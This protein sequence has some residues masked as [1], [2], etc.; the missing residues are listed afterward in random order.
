MGNK[1]RYVIEPNENI[2]MILDSMLAIWVFSI[3][4]MA[5]CARRIFE[6]P[7]YCTIVSALLAIIIFY[8][9]IRILKKRYLEGLEVDDE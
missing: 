1:K 4:V 3:T 7:L 2:L 5:S 8:E 9:V 6:L